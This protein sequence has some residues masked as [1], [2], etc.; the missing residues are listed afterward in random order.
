[1]SSAEL[2]QEQ[3]DKLREKKEELLSQM[4]RVDAREAEILSK[5]KTALTDDLLGLSTGAGRRAGQE[6]SDLSAKARE[7]GEMIE[8]AHYRLGAL[9]AELNAARLADLVAVYP[10][11]VGAQNALVAEF[12]QQRKRL[13]Q[14]AAAMNNQSAKVDHMMRYI[15]HWA[16]ETGTPVPEFTGLIRQGV[17]WNDFDTFGI[18]LDK[19]LI[20]AR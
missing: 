10:G 12:I 9:N 1:M 8:A 14:L 13:L 6:L 15:R 4:Q 11:E 18:L 7:L 3:I 17:N 19:H 2:V 5:K 16:R 20:Y